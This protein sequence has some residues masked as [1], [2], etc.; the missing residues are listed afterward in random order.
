ML[1]KKIPITILLKGNS[2]ELDRDLFGLGE[3]VSDPEMLKYLDSDNYRFVNKEA[4][5]D[6]GITFSH[7]DSRKKVITESLVVE[8]VALFYILG[9]AT[10]GLS[11]TEL[12]YKITSWL[13]DKTHKQET[14]VVVNGKELKT[15]EEIR[16]ALEEILAED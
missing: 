11:L 16:K 10:T 14:T 1:T 3:K 2:A 12:A 9:I 4:K 5:I 7:D 15:K 6:D 13:I 8:S